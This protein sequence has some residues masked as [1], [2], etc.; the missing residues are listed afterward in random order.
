MR[1]RADALARLDGAGAGAAIVLPA[2]VIGGAYS[3]RLRA[4]LAEVAPPAWLAFVTDREGVYSGSV[5]QE[6]VLGVFVRGDARTPIDC[7]RISLSGGVRRE[8]LATVPAPPRSSAPWLLPR[9][10]ADAELL[11]QASGL[12]SRHTDHGWRMS[13]GPL[14][15]NRQRDRL[16]DTPAPGRLPVV[17]ASD[18]RPGVGA[19]TP[20]TRRWIEIDP[21]QDW[22]VIDR[23]AVL[24]QRTTAP[25]Q[26][27]RIVAAPLA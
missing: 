22:L 5:L 24:V 13:T 12:P 11:E 7:E 20:R 14:V 16:H 25:E 18:V 10:P 17:W 4:L 23:P 21:G 9:D 27:R 6:T 26:P 15:W 1:S 2:S 8:L 3:Q 19:E